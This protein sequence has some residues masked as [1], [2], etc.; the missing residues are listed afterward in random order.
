MNKFQ[1]KEQWSYVR[2]QEVLTSVAYYNKVKDWAPMITGFKPE[3]TTII[4]K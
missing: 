2:L 1:D 3:K 4:K